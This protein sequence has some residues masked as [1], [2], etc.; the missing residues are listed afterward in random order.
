MTRTYVQEVFYQIEALAKQANLPVPR[1][2]EA[3]DK[4]EEST[5]TATEIVVK[6]SKTMSYTIATK[7]FAHWLCAF[8]NACE[9]K[10]K[11]KVVRDRIA[12]FIA[13][14][15]LKASGRSGIWHAVN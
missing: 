7:L 4:A 14:G 13:G 15:L 1:L 12:D 5:V 8:Y 10:E 3:D 2:I 11:S 9:G 6:K